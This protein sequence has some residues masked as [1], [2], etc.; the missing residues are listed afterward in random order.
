M[1]SLGMVVIL[2]ASLVF[3]CAF[4]AQDGI[5][6]DG[7]ATLALLGTAL[8]I[9]GS[10]LVAAGTLA[11]QLRAAPHGPA[12]QLPVEPSRESCRDVREKADRPAVGQEP[13]AVAPAPPG[14]AIRRP[15]FHREAA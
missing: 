4:L 11:R 8:A 6:G 2:S 10:V 7:S 14:P 15:G 1:R 9:S 3:G 5:L 13:A 12:D